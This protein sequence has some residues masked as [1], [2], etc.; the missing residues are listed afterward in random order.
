MAGNV[1]IYGMAISTP[2]IVTTLFTLDNSLGK[3]VVCDLMVGAHKK[4]EH[5]AINPWGQVP[6]MKD[7]DV[8]LA[9]CN[10]ILRYL[11]TKYVPAAYGPGDLEKQAEIDWAMDWV[12]S[13]FQNQFKYLWYPVV[14]FGPPPEDQAKINKD[15]IANL[16]TFAKKF[17]S[18]DKKFIG[19]DVLSIA[20]YRCGTCFWYIG[21][22]AIKQKTGFELP[23]RIVKYVDD[24]KAALK[25]ADFLKTAEGLMASKES[26]G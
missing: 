26:S 8:S 1:E 18:G 13:D 3:M 16:E 6:S 22:S 10:T 20:D 2:C 15:A 11:A 21:F 9:E 25:S 4:P 7:G 17:L 12:A 19:G 14:G 23:A 24:W 5:L